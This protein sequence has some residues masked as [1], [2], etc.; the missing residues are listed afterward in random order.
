MVLYIYTRYPPP[1]PDLFA[2]NP[3]LGE[4][5]SCTHP[6]QDFEPLILK[7]LWRHIVQVDETHPILTVNLEWSK[8]SEYPG[9]L[10]QVGRHPTII[11]V[12]QISMYPGTRG[13]HQAFD[14]A[15]AGIDRKAPVPLGVQDTTRDTTKTPCHVR[16][17]LLSH[18]DKHS[19]YQTCWANLRNS[20]CLDIVFILRAG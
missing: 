4:T 15:L 11:E 3:G 16:T 2:L 10:R 18:A 5:G 7:F 19:N 17:M 1:N 13:A 9:I 8:I 14:A 20:V 6:I 12:Q